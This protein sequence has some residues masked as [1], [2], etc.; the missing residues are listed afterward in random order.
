MAAQQ[1]LP[2]GCEDVCGRRWGRAPS[3]VELGAGHGCPWDAVTY[4]CAARFGHLD[5][6]QWARREHHCPW[7]SLTPANAAYAVTWR[8]CSWR[9]STAARGTRALAWAPL[10][11]IIRVGL[12]NIELVSPSLAFR[13]YKATRALL[14]PSKGR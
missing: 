7:N 2:V 13:R 3:C 14:G 10:A 11:F 4:A 12:H 6:L 9:A 1:R 5:V 8:C